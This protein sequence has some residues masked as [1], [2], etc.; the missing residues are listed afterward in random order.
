M[1]KL[2]VRNLRISFRT[3]TGAV[4]A[5]RDVSFNLNQVKRWP[6]WVNR[7]QASRS[8]RHGHLAGNAMRR[9]S[10]TARTC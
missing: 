8:P 7:D 9:S 1:A 4:R 3:I 6:L 5:V 10:T 2:E